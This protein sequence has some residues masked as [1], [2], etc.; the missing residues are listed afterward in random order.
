MDDQTTLPTP[1]TYS[2]VSHTSIDSSF[3]DE[4]TKQLMQEERIRSGRRT[5]TN[6][7]LKEINKKIFASIRQDI[8]KYMKEKIE[9]TIENNKSMKVLRRK[10][11]MKKRKI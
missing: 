4:T 9:Q 10:L 7:Q 5:T 3:D 2:V 8:K 6:K 11:P 1:P